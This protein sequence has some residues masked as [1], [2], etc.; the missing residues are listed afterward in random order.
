MMYHMV[1]ITRCQRVGQNVA[2]RTPSYSMTALA[3]TWTEFF[4]LQYRVSKSGPLYGDVQRAICLR[5]P[6]QNTTC[7]P[8]VAD[9]VNRM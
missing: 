4:S 6:K 2:W 3:S 5:P 9:Q 1:R 8:S 7:G